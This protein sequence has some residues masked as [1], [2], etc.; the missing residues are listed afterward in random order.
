MKDGKQNVPISTGVSVKFLE[1]EFQILIW[2]IWRLEYRYS[3]LIKPYST[4]MDHP[5]VQPLSNYP[6]Q[7]GGGGAGTFPSY[8]WARGE[9]HG[10]HAGS[11]TEG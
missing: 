3:R 6:V 2:L 11:L 8:H 9:V 1:P 7:G 10:G 4:F 5:S